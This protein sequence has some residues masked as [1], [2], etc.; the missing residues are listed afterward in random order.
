MHCHDPHSDMTPYFDMTP[1]SDTDP[2]TIIVTDTVSRDKYCSV[3]ELG[4]QATRRNSE[5]IYFI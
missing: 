5:I 4:R 3:P 1:A 2:A